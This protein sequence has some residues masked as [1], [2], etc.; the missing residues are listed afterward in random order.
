MTVQLQRGWRGDYV[1]AS[2]VFVFAF[3]FVV[4]VAPLER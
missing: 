1:D 3:A 2:G 4:R